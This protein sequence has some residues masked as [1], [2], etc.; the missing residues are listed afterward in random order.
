MTPDIAP[1]AATGP[2]CENCGSQDGMGQWLRRL[3]DSE[4][5]DILAAEQ[6]RRAT[7]LELADPQQPPPEFGPLPTPGDYTRAVYACTNHVIAQNLAHR[8]HQN[9]CA[10][11]NSAALPACDCTPEPEPTPAPTPDPTPTGPASWT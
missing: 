2:K 8:I 9:T 10:G 7:L 1:I 11:P 6:Q 4:F 3:T 5:A